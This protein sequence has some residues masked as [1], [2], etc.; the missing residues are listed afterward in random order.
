MRGLVHVLTQLAMG[1]ALSLGG[2]ALASEITDPL[3]D[4][5]EQAIAER[6]GTPLP[7]EE[8]GPLP[9]LVTADPETVLAAA[10]LFGA[11]EPATDPTGDPMIRA[12]ISPYSYVIFFYGCTDGTDCS[13]LLLRAAFAS[14]GTDHAQIG[15]WNRSKRFG[16][17]FLDDDGDPVLEMGINL[18][19]GVSQRNLE[20]SLDWWRVVLT[21]F[22]SHIGG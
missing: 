4:E 1:L 19:G 7:A 17:A 2:S 20:D 5:M 14:S 11:A 10:R 6:D 12:E 9:A 13:S 18:F 8:D 3:L 22:A 16:T 15:A 21:D